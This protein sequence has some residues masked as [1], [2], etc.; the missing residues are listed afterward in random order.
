MTSVSRGRGLPRV[1]FV[2][3]HWPLAPAYGAQQRVLN[4]GRLLERF[5]DLSWV[6]AP[7]EMEDEETARR[8]MSEFD[9][10]TVIRPCVL[11]LR[12]QPLANALHEDEG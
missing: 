7:S 10:Q 1:L 4:I 3:S 5:A 11:V 12:N 8:T 9:V 6:I 2:T